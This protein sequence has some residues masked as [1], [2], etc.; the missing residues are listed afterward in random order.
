MK[1]G[2]LGTGFG[3]FH[4]S[5][6]KKHGFV[7][8]IKI[9]GRNEEKLSKLKSDLGIEVT[10]SIDDILNDPK[11]DLVD[12]CL[13]SNL[14]REYVIKALEKGKSVFCETPVSTNLAD[15]EAI[16]E[17]ERQYGKKVFVDLFLLVDPSYRYI[18]EITKNN[19]FGK[20]K[21]IQVY[22]R[23][24]PFWGSLGLDSIVTNL[25]IHDVDFVTW[26]LGVP[27]EVTAFG[28]S[29]NESESSVNAFFAYNNSIAEIAGSSMMPV[30]YPFTQ[31]F[32]AVFESGAVKYHEECYENG[33]IKQMIEY[34][35]DGKKEIILEQANPWE[36]AINHVIECCEK[37]IE[38][39]L[40]VKNAISSFK[41]ALKIKELVQ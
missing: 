21:T 36:E 23:T 25:M 41:T 13:P 18:Q 3:A 27:N 10:N 40:S 28:V 32:D 29:K 38:T 26:L 33:P 35:A 22:R 39:V 1:V 12:V 30:S 24:A 17:A 31:G 19:T 7:E 15:A 20:L 8:S 11:I 4:A 5:I 14:H 9:F 16:A 2:I 34:S 37:D 6:Y